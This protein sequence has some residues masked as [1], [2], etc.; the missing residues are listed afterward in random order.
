MKKCISLCLTLAMLLAFPLCF[1]ACSSSPADFAK[2]D[3]AVVDNEIPF[4]YDESTVK[5][6]YVQN[7]QYQFKEEITV[8]SFCRSCDQDT[9][10]NK[11]MTYFGNK[12]VRRYTEGERDTYYTVYSLPDN[13]IFYVFLYEK[14]NALYFD[15][16]HPV[17]II[18]RPRD[19]RDT[20]ISEYVYE[21]DLPSAILGDKLPSF[22]YLEYYPP[23]EIE[24]MNNLHWEFYASFC[25]RAGMTSSPFVSDYYCDLY[26]QGRHE[27]VEG[28]IRCMQSVSFDT[29]IG[30]PNDE[31]YTVHHGAYTYDIYVFNDGTGI[32]F[33][34]HFNADIYPRHAAWQTEEI[35]LSKAEVDILKNLLVQWDFQNIPTW[36]PEEFTGFDGETTFVYTA[37]LGHDNLISMWE[38]TERYGIC[39]IREAIEEIVRDHVTVKLGRIYNKSRFNN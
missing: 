36:N 23:E 16:T 5:T 15:P 34:T 17:N 21:Q 31:D 32:L 7:K 3:E 39:H 8:E 27:E 10:Y 26:E 18:N 37:G 13:Q 24:R 6:F 14:D 4:V 38:S 22:C 33:F 11:F 29:E 19:I 12:V 20:T 2:G 1:T 35:T 30:N 9:P 28:A 25:D